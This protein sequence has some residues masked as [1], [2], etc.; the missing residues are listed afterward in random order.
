MDKVKKWITVHPHG[1]EN[2]GQPI[3][4]MDGQSKGE[5]VNAF[6]DKHKSEQSK[7]QKELEKKYTSDSQIVTKVDEIDKY[8]IN[9]SFES[10]YFKILFNTRDVQYY[11]TRTLHTLSEVQIIDRLAG[12]DITDG[13]CASLALAYVGNKAGLDVLD[14]RGGESRK[15]FAIKQT[16]RELVKL[17]GVE[18]FIVENSNDYSSVAELLKNVKQNK[19]Y[20]L[21]TGRH[22]AII[23]KNGGAF[24]YLELQDPDK[25]K[26]GFK[27]LNNAVLKERF[28]CAKKR[29]LYREITKAPSF[30]IDCESLGRNK[31]FQKLLGY[32]NTK[33]ELQKKG[34][35]GKIK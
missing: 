29:T 22:S 31:T 11:H 5:A 3:P 13:S 8:K 28:E 23:R 21:S 30:L 10:E 1:K 25:A 24:E 20:I 14:F 26:N 6:I 32:I 15:C 4:V 17:K 2:K 35:N 18:G 34:E 33:K 9:Q 19:E 27:K 7:T 16:M 12:G